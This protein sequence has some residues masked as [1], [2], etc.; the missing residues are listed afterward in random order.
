MGLVL[1]STIILSVI[2]RCVSTENT[3]VGAYSPTQLMI[4]NLGFTRRFVGALP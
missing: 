3:W 2:D 4:C 1:R